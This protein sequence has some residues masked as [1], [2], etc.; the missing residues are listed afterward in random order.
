M[1]V[2]KIPLVINHSFKQDSGL[3]RTEHVNITG[4]DFC[5]LYKT[6]SPN[7]ALLVRRRANGVGLSYFTY[8]PDIRRLRWSWELAFRWC[9]A[10]LV[11]LFSI[12]WLKL[13]YSPLAQE[14]REVSGLGRH[15]T[16]RDF[17]E[18]RLKI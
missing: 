6:L 11:L 1:D 8:I 13:P 5:S 3:T 10:V 2:L 4:Q 15:S 14:T 7:D 18:S 12:I 9:W 17:L 16:I